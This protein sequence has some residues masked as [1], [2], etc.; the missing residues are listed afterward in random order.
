MSVTMR[1]I[2]Q[3]DIRYEKEFWDL[4]K[5]FIQ[6]EKKRKDY[7]KPRRMKPIAAGEPINSLIWECEFGSIQEAYDCLNFFAGDE[8]HEELFV[9]QVEFF[10]GQKIEFF[11][12][13]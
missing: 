8:D 9:K 3:Y 1:L 5:K 6:L 12:N 13:I 10:K 2:Q 11:E 4:E 7:P